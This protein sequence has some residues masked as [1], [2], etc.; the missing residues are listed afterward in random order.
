MSD[1]KQ[2]V[3]CICTACK[4]IGHIAHEGKHEVRNGAVVCTQA[5]TLSKCRVCGGSGKVYKT[6]KVN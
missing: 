1:Q 5:P 6:V 3:P 4:G 2:K